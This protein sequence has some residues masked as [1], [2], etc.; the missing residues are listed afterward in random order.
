MLFVGGGRWQQS[1]IASAKNIGKK[2]AVIDA[3]PSK[4]T[5]KLA[6][7]LISGDFNQIDGF[8]EEVRCI[9]EISHVLS[10]NSDVASICASEIRHRLGLPGNDFQTIKVLTNKKLQREIFDRVSGLTNPLW[11]CDVNHFCLQYPNKNKVL[12]KQESAGSRDVFFFKNFEDL[13]FVEHANFFGQPIDWLVEQYFY[14]KEHTVEGCVI[15]GNVNIF[16]IF[17]KRKLTGSLKVSDQLIS[18][19]LNCENEKKLLRILR[20]FFSFLP[21]FAGLFHFEFIFDCTENIMPV[22]IA[23]RGAGFGVIDE[24]VSKII[25]VDLSLLDLYL[26]L[27]NVSDAN[28]LMKSSP[29]VKKCGGVRY[30]TP[31]HYKFKIEDR[32]KIESLIKKNVKI[33]VFWQNN[34]AG[35]QNKDTDSDRV[36]KIIVIGNE[37]EE[38]L[39]RLDE[40]EIEL[41][42]MSVFSV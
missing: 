12:K 19:N 28:A 1:A 8:W 37:R 22:E 11:S 27:G 10:F 38:V 33:E 23:G 42:S 3:S 36:A 14:G 6:S 4:T 21:E 26:Q 13:N 17:E 29:V 16:E 24:L 5:Q 2:V 39:A 34:N 41:K 7:K 32:K 31:S 9:S 20:Q 40:V 18:A 15:D 25:G 35:I 30:L